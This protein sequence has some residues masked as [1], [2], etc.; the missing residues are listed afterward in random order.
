MSTTASGTPWP[1]QPPV[2][3]RDVEAEVAHCVGGVISPLL[4]N[5]YLHVLDRELTA[6]RIG[7]LVR[8]ADD[9]VVLCRSGFLAGAALDAVREIL[10]GLGLELHPEKTKVVDLREG[11]EGLD[12][13]GC[14]FHARMSGRLWEQKRIVRYYLHRWPAQQAMK[15]LR[16]K[17]R[18]RTGRNR[19]G[20]DIRVVIADLN[21]LLRGWGN[22][23]RTGNAAVKFRQ[24]D[25]YVVRR[26]RTLMVKKRGRNLRAGQ[27]RA[28]TE[29]WFNG[30]GLY[31]LRGTVRYPRAA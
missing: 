25:S 5:I 13:L 21:P 19:A 18:D 8:Y 23:F 31:R 3:E 17:I 29:E 26:L 1:F 16:G 27:A 28:W 11:R 12:F 15:R 30:H 24:A 14:H 4:A 9:G 22:Y 7:E 20:A 2:A 10:A 6:R